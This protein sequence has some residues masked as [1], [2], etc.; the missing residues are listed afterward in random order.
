MLGKLRAWLEQRRAWRRRRRKRKKKYARW[1]AV[2]PGGSY[3]QFYVEETRR[4]IDAG[5]MKDGNIGLDVDVRFMKQRAQRILEAFKRAGCRPHHVVVDYG[6]GSLWVGEAFIDYLE[7]SNY[8]GLDVADGFYVEA[9]NR[10]PEPYVAERRPTLRVI[11]PDTLREVRD[12]KPDFILCSAVL[13]HVPPEDLTDFFARLTA[14][15]LPHTRIEI[16][17]RAVFFSHWEPPRFWRHSRFAIRSA[18]ATLGY[19]ARYAARHRILASTPGFAL[20]RR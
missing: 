19:E 15:A 16:A 1:L 13:M 6:C 8:V 10:F 11:A 20:I 7:P 9:L 4:Q 2:H 5:M 18:L 17:Y 14:V 12:R 3:A